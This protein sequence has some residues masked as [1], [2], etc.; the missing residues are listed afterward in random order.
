MVISATVRVILIPTYRL[1]SD[2]KKYECPPTLPPHSPA[3]RTKAVV[4][5]SPPIVQ[6][7]KIRKTMEMSVRKRLEKI[8]SVTSRIPYIKISFVCKGKGEKES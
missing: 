1:L 2:T 8:A 6:K 4:S 5:L 3:K 7:L